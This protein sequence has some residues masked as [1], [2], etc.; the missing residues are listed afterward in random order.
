VKTARK[1]CDQVIASIFVNPSQFGVNEDLD[2][3][4]RTEEADVNL[5]ARESAD[6]VFIPSVS[7]MYPSGM[8]LHINKQVGTFVSVHG[9]SH[10]L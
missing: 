5:L 3:Y 4:P 8:S 9:L 7:Q 2:K 6:V 10:Q 1:H